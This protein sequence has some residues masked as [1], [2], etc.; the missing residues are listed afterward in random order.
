MYSITKNFKFEASHRLFEMPIGHQCFCPHGHSYVV[1]VTIKTDELIN[2]MVLDFGKLKDFQLYL[3]KYYDHSTI[4]N[5]ND[6]IVIK[7]MKENNF[8]HLIMSKEPTAEHMAE[9]FW[10]TIVTILAEYNIIKKG[11]IKIEVFETVGNSG[12]YEN[13]FKI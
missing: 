12:N 3:D 8:K 10:N 1:K 6:E 9:D 11:I 5:L 2:N 13:E 4:V 7:Y